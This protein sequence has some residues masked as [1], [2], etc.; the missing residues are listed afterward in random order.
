M[1]GNIKNG[2]SLKKN[3][4]TTQ[5]SR[6]F[7]SYRHFDGEMAVEL[8]GLVGENPALWYFRSSEHNFDST[9]APVVHVYYYRHFYI[10][11]MICIVERIRISYFL[12]YLAW[13][14][15]MLQQSKN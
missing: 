2:F 6:R 11:S 15:F 9:Q 4:L 14:C 12:V 5:I 3:H 1:I 7:A 10:D 8:T 13:R